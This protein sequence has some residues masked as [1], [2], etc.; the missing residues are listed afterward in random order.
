[1]KVLYS[2]HTISDNDYEIYSADA[3][4]DNVVQL[5]HDTVPD[6]APSWSPDGAMIVFERV[7]ADGHDSDIYVIN[8]DGSGERVLM[9]HCSRMENPPGCRTGL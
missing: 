9:T 3:D 5:T 8:A 7:T 2:G 1:M 6:F 4:G